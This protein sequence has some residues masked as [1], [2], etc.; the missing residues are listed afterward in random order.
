MLKRLD[1]SNQPLYS[2]WHRH[3]LPIQG[4]KPNIYYWLT[5][6]VR[7]GQFGGL[8][9]IY[10]DLLEEKIQ[11][12]GLFKIFLEHLNTSKG[13]KHIFKLSDLSGNN[14]VANQIQTC[15]E[16]FSNLIWWQTAKCQ[17]WSQGWDIPL[18]VLPAN[19]V[20]IDPMAEICLWLFS[21]QIV[22]ALTPGLWYAFDC[23]PCK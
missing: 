15:P 9:V 18:T 19:S 21:M 5:S 8:S 1:W 6:K 4:R 22:S 7:W 16:L 14:Y 3:V 20:S 17:H 10:C 11:H 12:I 13:F 2:R 23:S